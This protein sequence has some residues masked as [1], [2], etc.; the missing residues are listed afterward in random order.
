MK[1]GAIRP[2]FVEPIYQGHSQCD[3]VGS[4]HTPD[5]WVDPV[6]CGVDASYRYIQRAENKR[7][8]PDGYT[9]G[10]QEPTKN[11]YDKVV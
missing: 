8:K 3:I 10:G 2:L 1:P 5:C 4:A 9:K 11:G 7:K 6:P